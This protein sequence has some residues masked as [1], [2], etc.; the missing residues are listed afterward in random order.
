MSVLPRIVAFATGWVLIIAGGVTFLATTLPGVALVL[1]S[2]D[3]NILNK[4]KL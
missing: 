4:V 1:W 3:P 2:I